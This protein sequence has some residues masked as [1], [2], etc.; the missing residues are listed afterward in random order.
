MYEEKSDVSKLIARK[1]HN[2]VKNSR[3]R[4]FALCE[5]FS[6]VGKIIFLMETHC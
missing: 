6:V 3:T 1:T 5:S 4:A 2:S